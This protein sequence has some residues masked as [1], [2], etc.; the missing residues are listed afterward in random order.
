MDAQQILTEL[1][2][3]GKPT[4]IKI[5]ARHGVTGPCYGV[6]YADLKPLVKEIGR[7]HEVALGLWNSGVHDARVV[8]TM[9]AEPEKMTRAEVERWLSDCTNYVMTEAVAGVAAKML[10]GLEMARSWIEKDG[11]WTTTAGW[12]VVAASGPQGKLT[13]GDVDGV[14]E[15]IERG[16]HTQPNR[17]RHA[18]NNAL[19]AIGSYV[20]ELR[21]RV[22]AVARAIGTV[23]VDHGETGCK[24]PDASAYIAKMVAHNAA[25]N[26]SSATKTPEKVSA[27][28][29]GATPAKAKAARTKARKAK[30]SKTAARPAKASKKLNAARKKPARKNRPS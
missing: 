6:N 20:D 22:L 15:M 18:M 2:K 16:I 27:R 10:D 28:R 26:A 8:A 14:L 11:E 21:P 13:A 7:N 23:H 29:A 24:T 5:Y 12:N 17:T 4:T 30:A 9:I 3:L 25:K 1:Q 19:I